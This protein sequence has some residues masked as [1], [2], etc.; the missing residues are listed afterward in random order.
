MSI[1][2]FCSSRFEDAEDQ[3]ALTAIVFAFSG[4]G[5][6][7]DDDGSF[8]FSYSSTMTLTREAYDRENPSGDLGFYVIR[9]HCSGQ[10][11]ISKGGG[12]LAW[13]KTVAASL[14]TSR[15]N[16]DPDILD[17]DNDSGTTVGISL[18]IPDP[19]GGAESYKI[20]VNIN[21]IGFAYCID[22]GNLF[23]SLV[24]ANALGLNGSLNLQTLAELGD[25]QSVISGTSPS[26][27]TLTFN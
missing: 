27:V 1:A 24:T 13:E 10:C 4:N 18:I 19:S 20:L 5:M 6:G 23:I 16:N 12:T 14:H 9:D 2:P 15:D 3:C 7:T 22:A 11:Y 25:N 21:I 17:C 26:T 8:A